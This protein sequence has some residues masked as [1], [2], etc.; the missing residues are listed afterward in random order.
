MF[1]YFRLS[2]GCPILFRRLTY[3]AMATLFLWQATSSLQKY[4]DARTTVS[5]QNIVSRK[6]VEKKISI[7]VRSLN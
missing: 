4:L 6:Q 5:I 1:R 3:L 7:T 2:N